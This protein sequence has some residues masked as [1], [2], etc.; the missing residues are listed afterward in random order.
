MPRRM[1]YYDYSHPDIE[2]QA[3]TVVLSTL[4]GALLVI[5]ACVFVFILVRARKG[6]TSPAPLTFSLPV[7][8][9]ARAPRALNGFGLW[10][11]M[12]IALTVVNYGFPIVQLALLKD[13]SVPVIP[14]GSR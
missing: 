14:I 9:H 12:M 13:A 10:I 1:A 3:W 5:S 7:H 8:P 11:A 4:G 2:S 6:S